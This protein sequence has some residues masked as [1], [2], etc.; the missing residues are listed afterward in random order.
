MTVDYRENILFFDDLNLLDFA[1]LNQTPFYLYSEK[2]ILNN[3]NSYVD[4][5]AIQ[6]DLL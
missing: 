6:E 1:L 2:T 3:Y 4:S 5:F